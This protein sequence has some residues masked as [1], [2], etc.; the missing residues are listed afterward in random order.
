M[1]VYCLLL[2]VVVLVLFCCGCSWF[3]FLS[4]VW[5]CGVGCVFVGLVV[6]GLSGGFGLVSGLRLGLFWVW[7][8]LF[9]GLFGWEW[10][11]LFRLVCY[12][13]S[14]RG[15]FWVILVCCCN[16]VFSGLRPFR[17]GLGFRGGFHSSCCGAS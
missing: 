5:C 6:I 17:G 12:V 4:G 9:L 11:V 16:I 8:V 1:C 2:D 15:W 13:G 10:F 7:A 14:L 3:E